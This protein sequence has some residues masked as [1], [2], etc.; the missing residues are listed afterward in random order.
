M[1]TIKR[2]SKG[3]TVREMQQ[4]LIAAG[5]SLPKYCLLYTSR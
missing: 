1:Q 4:L 3:E 5:Y 2:G